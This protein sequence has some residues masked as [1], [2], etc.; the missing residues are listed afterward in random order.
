MKHCVKLILNYKG[1]IVAQS[2]RKHMINLINY[3]I[4][5]NTIRM[6]YIYICNY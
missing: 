4:K 2:R 5:S 3:L 1:L 6:T